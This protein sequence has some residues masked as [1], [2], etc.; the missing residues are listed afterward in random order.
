M[1]QKIFEAGAAREDITP[2]VGTLLYG[3]TPDMV[4]T[5]VHDP[6]NVTAAAFRQGEDAA[7]LLSVTLGD[8]NTGL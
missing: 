6:L 3:Y 4:S 7:L 2:P 1:D 8:F 5:S